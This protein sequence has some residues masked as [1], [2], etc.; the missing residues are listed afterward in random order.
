MSLICML[1]MVFIYLTTYHVAWHG[2]KRHHGLPWWHD[3]VLR[4]YSGR[5]HGSPIA[6]RALNPSFST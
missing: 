5:P 2:G 1:G 3:G 6:S 4:Q